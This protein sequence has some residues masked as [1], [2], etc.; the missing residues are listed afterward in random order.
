MKRKVGDIVKIELAATTCKPNDYPAEVIEVEIEAF[1]LRSFEYYGRVLTPT[2]S[3]Y[4]SVGHSVRFGD[5]DIL[6]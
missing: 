4:T 5:G 3:P 1:E 6:N 2:K